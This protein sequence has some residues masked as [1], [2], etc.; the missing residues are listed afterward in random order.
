MYLLRCVLGLLAA[1][2]REGSQVYRHRKGRDW[3]WTP[4][5]CSTRL[6]LGSP[7]LRNA[8]LAAP[9]SVIPNNSHGDKEGGDY[10]QGCCC[11]LYAAHYDRHPAQ[12]GVL[13]ETSRT[14][15]KARQRE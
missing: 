5:G 10:D 8:R 11:Y 9:T 13:P 1:S 3:C 6:R 12:P 15:N 2:R 4:G 7:L 14:R